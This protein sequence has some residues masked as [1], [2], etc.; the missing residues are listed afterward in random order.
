M[1]CTLIYIHDL[2]VIVTNIATWNFL[3][4]AD[5]SVKFSDFT[6]SSILSFG[7]DMQ[8]TD[9]AGYLIYTDI[10]QLG[11]VM[12]EVVTGKLCKF[13]LYKNQLAGLATAVWLWRE[14]L[15]SIQDIWLSSIIEMC[16]TKGAFQNTCKLLAVLDL[17]ALE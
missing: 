4:A 10:G 1:A 3:F 9:D 8:V 17:V 6:E 11:T 7:T 15:P 2:C 16:W 5:L 12:Y 14:D 13:D